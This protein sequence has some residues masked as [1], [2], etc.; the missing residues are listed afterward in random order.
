MRLQNCMRP[1]IAHFT[2]VSRLRTE[3]TFRMMLITWFTPHVA[4][5]NV[6]CTSRLPTWFEA[7][8]I[9]GCFTSQIKWGLVSIP[10]TCN[11]A[12]TCLRFVRLNFQSSALTFCHCCPTD[13]HRRNQILEL[14]YDCTPGS[15]ALPESKHRCACH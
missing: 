8:G 10:H 14:G 15:A 7:G 9:I 6:F 1:L 5:M 2:V 3:N 13:V 4:S 12:T 11:L